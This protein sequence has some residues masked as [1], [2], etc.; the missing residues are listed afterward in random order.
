MSSERMEAWTKQMKA[1]GYA[2]RTCSCTHG[3]WRLSTLLNCHMSGS[4]NNP[5]AR[6][7]EDRIQSFVS[8]VLD[9]AHVSC[10]LHSLCRAAVRAHLMRMPSWPWPRRCT[11]GWSTLSL[12]FSVWVLGQVVDDENKD[13]AREKLQPLCGFSAACA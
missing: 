3:L 11:A 4:S 1:M 7:V 6:G 10:L 13:K 2:G 9:A 8:T 5:L 12:V